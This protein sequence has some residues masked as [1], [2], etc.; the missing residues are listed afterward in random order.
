M[1]LYDLEIADWQK[2]LTDQ[3]S[4]R[5]MQIW[6]AIH[7]HAL[8][9]EQ[10]TSL[11]KSLRKTLGSAPDTASAL[12]LVQL[13]SDDQRL[14]EKA[15]FQLDD[16]RV[17]ET[18]LMHYHDRSTVCISSQA[19]CA[20]NC[21]FCA[22]GQQGFFRHLR[23]GEI[24]E[25]VIWAVERTRITRGER[26]LSNIVFMGMGEPLANTRN[27]FRA[28]KRINEDIGI[29]ARHITVS[30]VGI[31]PGIRLFGGL[32][33]QFN[34]A[35][36]L[37]AANNQKRTSLVPINAKYPIE[38]LMEALNEYVQ[39]TR[40]RISFEWAM[41]DGVNDSREDARELITLCV[42]LEAH[43]NLIPLN[44]TPGWP[45]KGSPTSTVEDF[46]DDL[47]RAGIAVS[48]R[49]NRGTNIDAACG[50]LAGTASGNNVG[51]RLSAN[52][53][54]KIDIDALLE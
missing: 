18:V 6:K 10:L 50:Q 37:H 1:S 35:V 32:G 45:A 5:S 39:I 41:M 23:V 12:K 19:G 42:P 13:T 17:I 11:P 31:V 38:T 20:M 26:R 16:Q 28:L 21:S 47:D 53:S 34:L 44:P 27:V 4:F 2:L 43:V 29:G 48:I 46:A 22:T 49:D 24:V 8:R 7:E 36:S 54:V 52:I 40:R 25:Q 30:T 51:E 14:T 33:P 3:P 9:P 15:I